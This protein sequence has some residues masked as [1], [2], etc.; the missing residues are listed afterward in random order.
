[1]EN[2]DDLEVASPCQESWED[3]VGDDQ[4]RF[5]AG[6][7]QNVYRL[8]EMTRTQAE[9]LVKRAQG[10][11]EVCIRFARRE[12][13]TVLTRDCPDTKRRQRTNTWAKV[14]TVAAAVAGVVSASL[15]TGCFEADAQPVKPTTGGKAGKA[16][17]L[18]H[19]SAE[20]PAKTSDAET[21][22]SE[23]TPQEKPIREQYPEM[24]GAAVAIPPVK[25]PC[26]KPVEKPSEESA[27]E[28]PVAP[29][30]MGRMRA[31][32]PKPNEREIMGDL[33]APPAKDAQEPAP[34]EKGE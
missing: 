22:P 1:M 32:K 4:V 8:T 14:K 20:L 10:G 6:C 15:S 25:V 27:E 34:A 2:F 12:D 11:E 16:L 3:M 31:P 9:A 13:G 33:V 24:M 23:Q 30:R 5:C 7:E 21:T 28:L 17:P 29:I 19:E 18:A 26:E